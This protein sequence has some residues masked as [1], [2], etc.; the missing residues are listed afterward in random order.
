M[1]LRSM[2]A[3][4]STVDAASDTML[5]TTGSVVETAVFAALAAVSSAVPVRI[6]VTER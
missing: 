6:P 4:E 3:P 5:P 2:A 1:P